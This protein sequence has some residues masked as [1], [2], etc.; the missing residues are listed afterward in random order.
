MRNR[1]FVTLGLGLVAALAA[2]GGAAQTHRVM[3]PER[4]RPVIRGHWV[5]DV[6]A[7]GNKKDGKTIWVDCTKGQS[8]NKALENLSTPLVIEIRGMCSEQVLVE[9]SGVTLH[10]SD[11]TLDG[12]LAPEPVALRI[13]PPG[14]RGLSVTVENLTLQG[15]R[16]DGGWANYVNNCR[17]TGAGWASWKAVGVTAAG[18]V[19]TDVVVTGNWGGVYAQAGGE[20][21]CTGC[22]IKDNPSPGQGT[23]LTASDAQI[24]LADSEVS[25]R[26]GL[27][28]GSM[29]EIYVTGTALTGA[30][31][32][33]EGSTM[34]FESVTQ[35]SPP[36]ANSLYEGSRF[37]AYDSA[38]AGPTEL[39]SFSTLSLLGA[40]THQGDIGCFEAGDAV[41]DDPNLVDGSVTGCM[42][43]VHP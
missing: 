12:I 14:E 38:L 8:I 19:M 23:A 26:W 16:V 27:W 9:R 21:N 25:G 2:A 13:A 1:S 30:I 20:L 37:T 29:S 11:P 33:S 31:L 28:A 36:V 34:V 42:H 22:V 41:A 43:L 3:R 32:S 24:G 6:A 7:Q 4:P 18:L 10:G 17:I 35:A 39:Y 15:L 40:T 5:P